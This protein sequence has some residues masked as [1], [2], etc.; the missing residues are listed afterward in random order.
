MAVYLVDGAL[1]TIGSARRFYHLKRL[2]CLAAGE[3]G[4]AG[5][6]RWKQ[7]HQPVSAPFPPGFPYANELIASGYFSLDDLVGVTA[8]ELSQSLPPHIVSATVALLPAPIGV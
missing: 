8:A 2:A 1:V 5:V 6:W 4:M 3:D 7:D